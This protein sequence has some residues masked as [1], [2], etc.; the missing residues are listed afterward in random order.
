MRALECAEARDSSIPS[1]LELM[2][3]IQED[4]MGLRWIELPASANAMA[5]RIPP[6]RT[7][8]MP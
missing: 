6:F 4:A 7:T 2:M 5:Q 1:I 8:V 3:N